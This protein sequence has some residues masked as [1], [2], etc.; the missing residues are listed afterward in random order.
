MASCE[1]IECILYCVTNGK[2]YMA[3]I[4]IAPFLGTRSTSYFD[5]PHSHTFTLMLLVYAHY[6]HTEAETPTLKKTN[7]PQPLKALLE[8]YF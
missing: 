3:C 2:W 8:M 5:S 7:Y 1:W 6:Q 4:Y